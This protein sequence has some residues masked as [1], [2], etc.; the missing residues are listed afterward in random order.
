M[1]FD[2]VF[3]AAREVGAATL[4]RSDTR[5]K[6]RGWGLTEMG[7]RPDGAGGD[8][9]MASTLT[10]PGSPGKLHFCFIFNGEQG[11]THLGTSF[12]HMTNTN[13][14]KS[15]TIM[16]HLPFAKRLAPP[17]TH[18]Q[19]PTIH[20]PAPICHLRHP[21]SIM[22]QQTHLLTRLPVRNWPCQQ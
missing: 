10:T 9:R 21:P 3:T 5:A 20:W 19:R 18:P 4:L 13:R 6:S 16:N 14:L 22:H 7:A 8:L 2:Q 15:A 1:G 12:V 17:A 11:T